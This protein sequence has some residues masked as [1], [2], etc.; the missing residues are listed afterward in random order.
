M[1]KLLTIFCFT[2]ALFAS[3]ALSV[4]VQ[5][6]SEEKK[7]E[8]KKVVYAVQLFA[9]QNIDLAQITLGK[10]SKN[11]KDNITL[12]K[13][14][15][16]I[17]G[18]YGQSES[19]T[20]TKADLQKAYE[21]GYKNS[22]IITSTNLDM[23]NNLVSGEIKEQEKQIPKV[24]IKEQE[25]K[26]PKAEKNGNSK[27]SKSEKSNILLKAQNAYEKGDENEAM[28]YYEMLLATG[29]KSQKI[30][31]NLCY[32]Y[33]KRGA[34]LQAKEIIDAEQFNGKL[35]YAYA[36][37]AVLGNQ[38]NYYGDLSEYIMVDKSGRLML[39]SGYYFEK[40]EDM[41]R[42]ASFYK[43]AYEKNPSDLYNIFA[44]ARILDMQQ[45]REALTFY[46]KILSKIDASHPLHI[47]VNER[48]KELEGING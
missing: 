38:E 37:G 13:I 2:F 47:A 19:Y 36:Y 26:T 34:W 18:R 14:G 42:A 41:Q 30:K 44:Y 33:G 28:I 39:L 6:K 10:I 32:L 27:I 15:N 4:G 5:K 45:N 17:V 31:N 46:K 1:I 23:K 43:I 24:E 12:H 25:K 8:E 48:I 40:R 21:A 7:E 3:D 16:Y 35:V 29:E 22:Y 20:Q 11:I 9:E